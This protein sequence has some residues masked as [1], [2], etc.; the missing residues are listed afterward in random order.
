MQISNSWVAPPQLQWM[1]N[2]VSHKYRWAEKCYPYRDIRLFRN[3]YLSVFPWVGVF[4]RYPLSALVVF[5]SL[6]SQERPTQGGGE[7][8][9]IM[10]YIAVAV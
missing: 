4:V 7:E 2:T 8:V 5:L 6:M 9:L 10:S 1:K 3:P